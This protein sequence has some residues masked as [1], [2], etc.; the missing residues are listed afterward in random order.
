MTQP[1]KPNGQF[2]R[3]DI[4]KQD[5]DRIIQALDDSSTRVEIST[6]HPVSFDAEV[7]GEVHHTFGL[8]LPEYAVIVMVGI[9]I[10]FLAFMV[11]G[12]VWVRI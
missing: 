6:K 12:Y 7:V 4:R 2:D 10:T 1:R 9:A 3:M 8:N 11:A 5:V